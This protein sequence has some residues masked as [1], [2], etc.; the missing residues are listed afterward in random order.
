MLAAAELR[1]WSSREAQDLVKDQHPGGL[2]LLGRRHR[3]WRHADLGDPIGCSASTVSRLEASRRVTDMELLRAAAAAVGVPL[4]EEAHRA[5][6]RLP[7]MPPDVRLF[8]ISPA[9]GALYAAGVHWAPGN[10]GAAL[11]AGR[12]LRAELFPTAERKSRM[13]T[14]LVRAWWQWGKP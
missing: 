13:H 14:D 7:T 12:G 8:R 1:I 4:I 11:E 5:A 3:R 9:A 6:R 2:I 10:A